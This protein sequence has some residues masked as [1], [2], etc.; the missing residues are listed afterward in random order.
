MGRL[1]KNVFDTKLLTIRW[2]KREWGEET[3][4]ERK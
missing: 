2:G 3:G 4:A 1:R